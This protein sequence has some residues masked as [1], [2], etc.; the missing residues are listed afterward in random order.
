MLVEEVV[1]REVDDEDSTTYITDSTCLEGLICRYVELRAT[2]T[3][4]EEVFT[5][6]ERRHC[7]GWWC[8]LSFR[9]VRLASC[10]LE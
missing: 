3:A 7:G 10:L 4:D 2:S 1:E 5:R 6:L 9:L 8:I